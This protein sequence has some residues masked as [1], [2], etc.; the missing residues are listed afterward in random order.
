MCGKDEDEL[1]KIK[2]EDAI[3]DVCKNCSSFGQVIIE[4][5]KEIPIKEE[6]EEEE[7]ELVD[8]FGKIIKNSREKMNISRK[9]LAKKIK[10]KE[11][12]LRRI[13]SENLIPEKELAKKIEK[14]LGIKILQKIDESFV[15]KEYKKISLTI[16]DVVRID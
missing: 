3:I 13:E 8:N 14:E 2:V 4:K 10:I 16:G 6:I 9:E 12:I 1:I 5:K 15:K 7:Y 11:N